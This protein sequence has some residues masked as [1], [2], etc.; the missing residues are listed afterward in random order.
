[1]ADDN[2]TAPTPAPIAPAPTVAETKVPWYFFSDTAGAKSLTVTLVMVSFFLTSL[3]YVLSIVEKI[4]PVV[5]RPFDIGACGVFFGPILALYF[6]RKATD[7]KATTEQLKINT[8]NS[9]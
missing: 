8:D 5:I 9:K 7:A 1:M 4:G 2:N 3:A 6:G